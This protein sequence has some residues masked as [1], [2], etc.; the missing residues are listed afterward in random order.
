MKRSL[1][2]GPECSWDW[3]KFY[4]ALQRK[5]ACGL[6]GSRPGLG[7]ILWAHHSRTESC[8]L[9]LGLQPG[10]KNSDPGRTRLKMLKMLSRA[11]DIWP[12]H[13]IS[14]SALSR[15]MVILIAALEIGNLRKIVGVIRHLAVC[16]D[17]P[18]LVH[19]RSP[20][21]KVSRCVI[22]DRLPSPTLNYELCRSVRRPISPS[23]AVSM[24]YLASS[25]ISTLITCAHSVPCLYA[26]RGA[27]D[28]RTVDGRRR[29]DGR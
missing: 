5:S 23:T 27:Q 1:N 11:I 10:S 24:A 2:S 8:H 15:G 6:H 14:G 13:A 29:H 22:R 20:V 7:P 12:I 18:S 9:A 21:R 28:P 4:P 3:A 26:L 16:R 19:E 17:R 25:R